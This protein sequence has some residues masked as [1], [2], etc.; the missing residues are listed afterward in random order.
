[1]REYTW[2][3]LAKNQKHM[4]EFLKKREKQKQLIDIMSDFY[5]P[6]SYA[7]KS[8]WELVNY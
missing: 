8:L 1:M 5:M 4:N 7:Y 2:Q 3:V 6:D